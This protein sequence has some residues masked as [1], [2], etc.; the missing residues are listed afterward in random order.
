MGNPLCGEKCTHSCF[1]DSLA[2]PRGICK[3]FFACTTSAHPKAKRVGK[4]LG[5]KP[6]EHAALAPC[7][8]R[9]KAAPVLWI[10]SLHSALVL[11]AALQGLEKNALTTS[12]DLSESPSSSTELAKTLH[13]SWMLQVRPHGKRGLVGM[14]AI[15]KAAELCFPGQLKNRIFFLLQGLS[16]YL[17]MPSYASFTC[18]LGSFACVPFI[19]ICTLCQLKSNSLPPTLSW[20]ILVVSQ[21]PLSW[22]Q[23][24]VYKIS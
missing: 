13:V 23:I 14:V 21:E 10:V 3:F 12:S 8:I 15:T 7:L 11:P 24:L 22:S 16:F 9:S 5:R 1:Q 19:Y 6:V 17:V 4:W 20:L 18:V 2:W